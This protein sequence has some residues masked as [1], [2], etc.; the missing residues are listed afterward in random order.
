MTN[1]NF[2]LKY[3]FHIYMIHSMEDEFKQ[4]ADS[5]I[6]SGQVGIVDVADKTSIEVL[7]ATTGVVGASDTIV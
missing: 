5:T 2:P 6:H 3:A 1:H 7:M 4:I